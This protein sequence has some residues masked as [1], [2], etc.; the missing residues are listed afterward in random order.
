MR[1]PACPATGFGRDKKVVEAHA[2]TGIT[3]VAA[4]RDGLRRRADQ[5]LMPAPLRSSR[6]NKPRPR[7]VSVAARILDLFENTS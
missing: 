1:G 5:C 4:W 3:R 7:R 6:R 2:E